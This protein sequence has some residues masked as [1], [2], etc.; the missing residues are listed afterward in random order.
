MPGAD[1]DPRSAS[2][3]RTSRRT[4][5]RPST[6]A[7]AT[8]R[9]GRRRPRCRLQPRRHAAR[10]DRHAAG[11]PLGRAGR[12]FLQ[13]LRQT[14]VELGISD[15]EMEKGTLRVDANVSVRPAGL[16]RAA[17]ALGAE[18]HELVQ[19][20]RAG[21][22]GGEV[23]EQIAMYESGGAVEQETLR[24]R[25]GHRQ[26]ARRTARRRRRRTTAISRSPT[27]CRSSRRRDARRAAARRAAGVAGRRGS[28][29]SRRRSAS[30]DAQ[31]LVTTGRD[32]LYDACRRRRG[33]EAA[34]NVVDE[35][36]RRC[37]RR[38]GAVNAAELAKLVAA[39]DASRAT[40]STRRCRQRRRRLQRRRLPRRR[41]RSPTRPSS[42]RS[43]SGSSRPTPAR[44]PRTAA[45]RRACSASSSAR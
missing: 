39:R 38:P 11:H 5:R 9:I 28:G 15:A 40:R 17:H 30:T 16:R 32:G 20:R 4:P 14:I 21:D 45:A 2:S 35:P 26:A 36:A 29:G 23:R 22:R 6:S 13:L 8:G 41:R 18:E 27:S 33:R 37:R 44:S 3:A 43:S 12:R 1:G 34:A 24:L 42:S 25:A 31:A 10:R 7:A 19:L